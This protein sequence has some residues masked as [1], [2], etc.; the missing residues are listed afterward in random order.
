MKSLRKLIACD[1]AFTALSAFCLNAAV[2]IYVSPAGNDS[3]PGSSD[4]PVA[5]MAA[6]QKLARSSAGHQ[7]VNVWLRGVTYYLP[8]ALVFTAEDSGTKD[9]PVVFQNYQGAQPVIS[10]GSIATD[11]IVNLAA[12]KKKVEVVFVNYGSREDGAAGKAN[13]AGLRKPASTAFFTN[14]QTPLTN[15]RLGGEACMNLRRCC[16]NEPLVA[17]S[18]S[19][20][21]TQSINLSGF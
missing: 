11:E 15:G 16:S 5:T 7:P 3:D 8:D 18:K 4:K 17:V 21:Q 9:A 10:G 1:I 13:V 12:F 14:R 20:M 19:P 6:A 2:N